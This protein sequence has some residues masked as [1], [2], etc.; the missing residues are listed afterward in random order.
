MLLFEKYFR[1]SSRICLGKTPSSSSFNHESVLLRKSSRISDAF[2][3]IVYILQLERKQLRKLNQF[4]K[5][6]NLIA[7]V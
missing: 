1:V 4:H 6:C 2:N 7:L 3:N 5:V